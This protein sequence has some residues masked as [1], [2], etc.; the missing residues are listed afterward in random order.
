MK[1][2]PLDGSRWFVVEQAGLIRVFDN[3]E[4]AS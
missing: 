4:S 3:D 2:A 1:Q